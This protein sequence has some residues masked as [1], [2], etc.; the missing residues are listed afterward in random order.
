[1]SSWGLP[2][3]LQPFAFPGSLFGVWNMCSLATL[4]S[5]PGTDT[6]GSG[7]SHYC[8]EPKVPHL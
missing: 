4:S 6:V 1:M 8:F 5:G 2:L 3:S 7:W